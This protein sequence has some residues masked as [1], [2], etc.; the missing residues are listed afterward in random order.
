VV[1]GCACF[2]DYYFIFYFH[3]PVAIKALK[4]KKRFEKQL[5][6]L[7]G[8]L[9]TLEYQ[10]ESLENA[11]SNAE[12]LKTMGFAAKAYKTVHGDFDIDKVNDL[13]DEIADQQELATEITNA[14]SRPA[15]GEEIDEVN[16]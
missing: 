13:R 7:D 16:E 15:F 9:T 11:N 10:R 8:T 3:F 12:I 1:L 4:T 14:I 5:Q 2:I 6:Q